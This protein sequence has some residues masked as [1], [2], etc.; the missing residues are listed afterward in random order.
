[1]TTYRIVFSPGNL[2]FSTLEGRPS[3][4]YFDIT[5]ELQHWVSATDIK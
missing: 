3:A 2:A 1:M 4:F 5:P